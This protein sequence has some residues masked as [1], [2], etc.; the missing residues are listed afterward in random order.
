MQLTEAKI[1]DLTDRTERAVC[2][3]AKIAANDVYFGGARALVLLARLER[4][5]NYHLFNAAVT[6][7]YHHDYAHE[8]TAWRCP[9]CDAVVFGQ[10]AAR[11]H[12]QEEPCER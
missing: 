6:E 1:A 3:L 11:N 4:S 12:C 9:E 10:T 7:A 2:R 5:P 8:H